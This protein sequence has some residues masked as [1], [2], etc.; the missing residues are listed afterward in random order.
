[1]KNQ[2]LKNTGLSLLFLFI[3]LA[4]KAQEAAQATD[5]KEAYEFERIMQWVFLAVIALLVF[6]ASIVVLRAMRLYQDLLHT[7][8]AR[9]QGLPIFA[10]ETTPSVSKPSIFEKIWY[11]LTGT[12][13]VAIEREADIMLAHPHDGI[14]ELDNR[15]PP[16]WINMFYATILFGVAYLAYYH[17]FDIGALQ[18]EEYKMA[19]RASDLQKAQAA[20]AVADAVNETNVTALTGVA[21]L[22]IGN[23]IFVAKCVACHGQKGE[24]G[25][26][27]NMT[28]DYWLHGGSIKDVF[29]V[30]KY[31]V[32]EKG[33]IAWASQLRPSEMQAVSSY[34]LSLRG[35]NPPNAKA[36]QG[37]LYKE[38][39]LDSVKK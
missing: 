17:Y 6:G 22:A 37:I 2:H 5:S 38:A 4:V 33:M 28:D 32:P 8:I 10:T 25:V 24:G 39:A 9:E 3:N 36:A 26:G 7:A 16:W 30:V 20:S 18:E 29:K 1:M 31:G 23:G 15:L 19:I 34:I 27:P 11:Q 12:G 21:D 35:T 14:Y 13:A